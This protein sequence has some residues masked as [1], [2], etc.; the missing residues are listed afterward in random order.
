MSRIKKPPSSLLHQP[1]ASF[2][3]FLAAFICSL[4]SSLSNVTR[5]IANFLPRLVMYSLGVILNDL[6]PFSWSD[7]SF[8]V[9]LPSETVFCGV[10]VSFRLPPSAVP[11]VSVVL[12]ETLFFFSKAVSNQFFFSLSHVRRTDAWC[13]SLSSCTR[14]SVRLTTTIASSISCRLP[15]TSGWY[16]ASLARP[17]PSLLAV[18]SFPHT[19]SMSPMSLWCNAPTAS[20]SFFSRRKA[21]ASCGLPLNWVYMVPNAPVFGESALSDFTFL[22]SLK[23]FVLRLL[24]AIHF[25]KSSRFTA[26]TSILRPFSQPFS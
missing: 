1:L 20:P 25:S 24:D 21:I 18:P 3:S 5:C 10:A 12:S 26:D 13:V 23:A 16:L 2:A 4:L 15:R 7:E 22:Y 9:S 17:K 6:T 19:K 14:L 11:T 8:S